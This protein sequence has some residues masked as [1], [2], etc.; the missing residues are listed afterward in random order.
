METNDSILKEIKKYSAHID[1][2]RARANTHG[3]WLFI[4]TLGCW[5]VTEPSIRI[6]AFVMLFFIFLFLL[7][8]SF[9]GEK[10][11]F[12]KIH[13]DIKNKIVDNLIPEQQQERF[14]DLLI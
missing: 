8:G 3:I 9:P 1:R 13:D 5:G 7:H 14:H 10:R 4:A 2:F 6:L 11:T 12:K